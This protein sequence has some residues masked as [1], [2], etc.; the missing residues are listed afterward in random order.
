MLK[1]VIVLI[2]LKFL[3]DIDLM[4][5]IFINIQQYQIIKVFIDLLFLYS[6]LNVI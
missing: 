4:E 6:I 5:D 1:I 3:F 2:C